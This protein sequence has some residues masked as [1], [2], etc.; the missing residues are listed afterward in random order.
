MKDYDMLTVIGD[1]DFVAKEVK[2]HHTCRRQYLKSAEQLLKEQ[3][4]EDA[5]LS[6]NEK[7][8]YAVS[9]HVQSSVLENK[10]AELMSSVYAHYLNVLSDE[11]VTDI[12]Y[13]SR[14][15]ERRLQR[16]FKGDIIIE[17]INQ[18]YPCKIIYYSVPIRG[19]GTDRNGLIQHGLGSHS[20]CRFCLRV[21]RFSQGRGG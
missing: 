4:N 12:N 3:D 7:A 14:C 16:H 5:E 11:G 21:H 8:F 9:L 15:L 20:G 18:S 2:Y 17:T 6:C 10:H 13:E 1:I 19:G